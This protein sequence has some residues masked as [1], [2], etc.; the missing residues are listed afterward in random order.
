ME[1]ELMDASISDIHRAM[2]SGRLSCRDLVQRYL[3]RI[4]AYDQQ[5]PALN[6]ILQLSPRASQDAD[7]LDRKFR[8]SG[9]VGPLHGI[10]V[11]LKDNYDTADLPTTAGCAAMA[12]AQPASPGRGVNRS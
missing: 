3:D 12:A 1:F 6:A 9:F 2:R 10:P 4:A 11:V 7:E 8:K 5:G